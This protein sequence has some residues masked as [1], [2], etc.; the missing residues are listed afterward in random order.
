LS[1]PFISSPIS[2]VKAALSVAK[3]DK[4]DVVMDLGCGDGRVPVIAAKY[5]G[6]RGICVEID[7]TLCALAEANARYNNVEGLVEVE[8]RDLFTY[9][10]S[11][12]TVIYAYLYGSILSFLS[13]K[14]EKELSEGSRILT[15]DFP[16]HG[17]IPLLIKR[18]IDE[19]GVIR[20]IY[21][22]V[23]GISNPSAWVLRY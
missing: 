16:I 3:V 17:W 19:S 2:V 22:Y 11:R 18:L 9:N 8:C 13:S 21:L 23:M 15:I 6:A 14:F 20:S 1:I 12:A 10:Y 4:S 5:H 7:D